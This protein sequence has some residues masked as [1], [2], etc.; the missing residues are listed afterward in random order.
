MKFADN[1]FQYTIHDTTL[2][3]LYVPFVAAT[4]ARTRVFL[5]A[6]V[7]PIAYG[8]GGLLLLLFARHI[9]VQALSY[10]SCC[11]GVGMGDFDPDCAASLP[12]RA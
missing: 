6:V 4:R 9:S 2:Q 3:A 7:K 8:L 10:V 12:T 11:I 5:D 1:G